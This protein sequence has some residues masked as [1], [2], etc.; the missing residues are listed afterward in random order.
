LTLATEIPNWTIAIFAVLF[1]L[2]Q[3]WLRHYVRLW[4]LITLPATMLHEFAHATVGLATFAAP[5][6]FNLL[7]KR[8]SATAWR[9]GYVGFTNLRWWNGGP[10]ALA[11][12]MWIIVLVILAR[13]VPSL[14]T[15]LSLQ[16]SLLMGIGLVWLWIAV[17]PSSSDWTLA[18]QY[19]PS[20]IVYLIAL[21]SVLYWLLIP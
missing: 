17:A 8:V 7:P 2:I 18:G 12:L 6:S 5:S 4:A 15:V 10:I 9:L 11:P 3:Y 13:Y 21:S 19:W 16:T 20:A 14:P 1:W